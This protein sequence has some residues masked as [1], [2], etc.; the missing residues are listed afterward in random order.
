MPCNMD[1]ACCL[2]WA[3]HTDHCGSS[4]LSKM[5]EACHLTRTKNAIQHGWH[6][7]LQGSS[8]PSDMD[9]ACRLAWTKHANQQGPKV[10]SNMDHRCLLTWKSVLNIM[11]LTCLPTQTKHADQ[12]SRYAFQHSGFAEE[13]F[14][15]M[16][17]VG[18]CECST[19]GSLTFAEGLSEA[20]TWI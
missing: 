16:T 14:A 12:H 1:Q 4:V 2:T 9:Q 19:Y 6:A 8:V 18:C 15:H 17:F 3:K 7:N 10:P 5:D 11:N 20:V 13:V